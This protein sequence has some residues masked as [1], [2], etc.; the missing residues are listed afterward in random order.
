MNEKN[1]SDF[2]SN[3]PFG[4]DVAVI[5]CKDESEWKELRTGYL[6]ASEAACLL[7]IGFHDNI[8]LWKQKVGMGENP[9]FSE[10]S[11]ALMNKGRKNEPLSR[12]Q[13]AI[14]TGHAVYDG[15]MK[16]VVNTNILDDKGNPF[17]ACTLDAVGD[18]AEIGLYD[19]E[20]KRGENIKMFSDR[21]NMPAKYRAQVLHQMLVTGLKHAV[22]VARIVWWDRN[23]RN[24]VERQYWIDADDPDTQWDMDKL[25]VAESRF[26]NRY[27]L[28][29]VMPPRILPSI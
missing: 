13:W 25:L 6:C 10:Q 17:L 7:G 29:K 12:E 5:H 18:C 27:V 21:D 24:V 2:W 11:I 1:N 20:L 28:P 8:W 9:N 4:E 15:T 14:D 16:L 19:I 26:W 22:L 23:G 3:N